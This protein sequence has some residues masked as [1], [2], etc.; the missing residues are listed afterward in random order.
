MA[1]TPTPGSNGPACHAAWIAT[2]M[3][4][5]ACLFSPTRSLADG[6]VPADSR[7]PLL[8]ASGRHFLDPSG[9]AVFLRGVNLANDSKVP[10]FLP[11]SDPSELDVLARHGMNVIRLLFIW[12]A[13]EPEPG[14]YDFAYLGTLRA[15]A[16]AA[17]ARGL[18]VIVDVHQ[19]GFSRRL[20]RGC[21]SGF[22]AW[23]ISP[24][25]RSR[26][27]DNGC[28]CRN[29]VFREVTDPG[30]HRSFADFYADAHGVRTRY[31][32]MLDRIAAAFATVPGV[33]G[34]DPLNEPWGDEAGEL[35]PLYCDAAAALRVRHPTAIVFLAGHAT[36]GNGKQTRMPRPAIDNFAYSPHYYTPIVIMQNGWHGRISAVDRGFAAMRS[37]ADEWGVPLF[38]GEFGV[39]ADASR[40]GDYIALVYDRL[41]LALASGT[42]WNYTPHWDEQAGDGWNGENYNVFEASGAA[43]ASYRPRP[44][45]RGVAG[46]PLR[47]R[48]LESS[49]P[50]EGALLELV[51]DHR[52]E[53][54]ETEVFMPDALFPAGSSLQVSPAEASC[55]RDLAGQRLICRAD[56]AVT[57]RVVVSAPGDAA[58]GGSARQAR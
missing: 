10:P 46:T 15:I 5:A 50:G 49:P 35:L 52:P 12:E 28:G 40:A 16:E 6:R 34:Y 4:V 44:F 55:R 31:L 27:P 20:A 13:F 22:P 37:K 25:A 30:V 36:T 51:W 23:A 33:I 53:S 18:Y 7:P 19:D 29:W 42:Q 43:R 47:F 38:V 1:G 32:A 57:V 8:R 17:W 48:Y 39:A 2:G 45:P 3:A 41:D 9:R 26:P 56:R 24:G 14:C 21:G 54:G 58:S 11:L